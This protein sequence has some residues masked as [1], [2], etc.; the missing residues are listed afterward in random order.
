MDGF[1]FVLVVALA[2]SVVGNIWFLGRIVSK[3]NKGTSD[4]EVRYFEYIEENSGAIK[5]AR[6]YTIKGQIY[7]H[8]LPIGSPFVVSEHII[9]EFSWDKFSKIRTEIL[10]PLISTGVDLGLAIK[11]AGGTAK[12]ALDAA[13]KFIKSKAG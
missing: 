8:G 3:Q 6:R 10:T 13:S 2:L 11:G 12:G 7:F 4:H 9:E 1:Q 5:N